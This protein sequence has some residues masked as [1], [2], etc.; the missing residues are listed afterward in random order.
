MDWRGRVSAGRGP[1]ALMR[2]SRW[3]I[4]VRALID[5]VA[6]VVAANRADERD[7]RPAGRALDQPGQRRRVEPI[8]GQPEAGL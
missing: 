8:A 5:V 6:L 7:D 1:E 2:K 3:L 4:W